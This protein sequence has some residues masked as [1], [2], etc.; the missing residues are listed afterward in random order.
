[1]NNDTTSEGFA[2]KPFAEGEPDHSWG[3]DQL[4][5][6]ARQQHDAIVQGET[7]LAGTYWR[8]GQVLELARKQLARGHWSR[9]LTSLGV[10]KVR[11]SKA[12]AIYR[13]FATPEALAGVAVEEAYDQRQ[14]RQIDRWR[15]PRRE[16]SRS[17]S[18]EPNRQDTLATF[19]AE[20]CVRAD[21]FVDMATFAEQEETA[22]LVPV[23]R[24]AI[25]RLQQLGRLLGVAD[26]FNGP[27][28]P[29]TELQ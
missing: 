3:L 16:D 20:I 23:L 15:K 10:H 12:R 13:S 17:E 29:T 5:D 21:Q 27:A 2:P 1:M 4:G 25:E 24:D 19:L 6:Y 7:S 28:E 8:L 14:R 18:A 9:F 22:K 26:P 11:A